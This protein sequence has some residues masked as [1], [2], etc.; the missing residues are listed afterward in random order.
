MSVFPRHLGLSRGIGS[1]L[2]VADDRGDQSSAGSC[3]GGASLPPRLSLGT[4]GVL[5]QF[6]HLEIRDPATCPLG[7]ELERRTDTAGVPAVLSGFEFS[8]HRAISDHSGR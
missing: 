1:V 3:G 7:C 8:P 2:C 5:A 6:P 4:A